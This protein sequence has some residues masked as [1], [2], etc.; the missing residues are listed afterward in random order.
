[1][2]STMM[3][4]GMRTEKSSEN[5][6]AEEIQLIAMLDALCN[7]VFSYGYQILRELEHFIKCSRFE[8]Q[9]NLAKNK[10]LISNNMG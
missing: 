9:Y 7:S 8:A 3:A 10:S 4:I 1:M 6:A 5:R 2:I